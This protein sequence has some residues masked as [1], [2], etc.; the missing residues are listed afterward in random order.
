ELTFGTMS[1]NKV[2]SQYSGATRSSSPTNSI[3]SS[4]TSRPKRQLDLF[5]GDDHLDGP[6]HRSPCM[7]A[8][9]Y[10]RLFARSASFLGVARQSDRVRSDSEL[11][12]RILGPPAH[13]RRSGGDTEEQRM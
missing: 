3:V 8:N 12:A 2:R 11:S 6:C 7:R 9:S 1:T 4:A 10:C 5:H 13:T